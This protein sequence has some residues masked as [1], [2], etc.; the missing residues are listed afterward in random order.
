[1]INVGTR[2]IQGGFSSKYLYVTGKPVIAP[3]DDDIVFE[4]GVMN[5]RD[6]ASFAKYAKEVVAFEPSPRNYVI[7]DNNLR[8]FSNVE[9]VNQGLWYEKDELDVLLGDDRDDDGFLEPDRNSGVSSD[10]I[11]V[12]TIDSFSE[13]IELGQPNFVKVEAEGAELEV[14]RGLGE[15]R[16]RDIVVNVGEERSGRPTGTEVMEL[17]QPM[18]YELVIIKRGHILF[19]TQREV[20]HSGFRRES[21]V[22]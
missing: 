11:K 5:G 10:S 16:P 18:G 2:H 9:L 1:M 15:L 6:T 20:D 17:L 12:D 4:A 22:L 19:F 8:R 14:L 21:T 7:A 3:R 13:T